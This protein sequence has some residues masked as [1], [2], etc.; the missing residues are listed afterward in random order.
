MNI[1]G[2]RQ[3]GGVQNK[4]KRKE[5]MN[6]FPSLYVGNLPKENFFDLDFFKFFTNKGY[7]VKSAKVVLDS[8]TQKSRGYG[9]LQFVSKG[10]ADKC[11][12]A[13]NNF[14]FHNQPLRIVDSISNPKDQF[15]EAANILVKNID[16]EVSQQEIHDLFKSHGTIVSCKLETFPDGGSRGY[17]FVQYKEEE[18]AK[19]A[20]S[21]LNGTEIRGKKL[22]VDP[23][24]KDQTGPAKNKSN[25]NLF[26]KNLPAGTDDIKLKAMFARFGEIESASLK[27]DEG[28][29]TKDY[30]WV[31][32]KDANNAQ[33][34]MTEMNKQL[35]ADGRVLIV[36]PFISKKENELAH[37]PRQIDPEPH[38]HLQF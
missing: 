9:Y 15:K 6:R 30:G 33:K 3:G 12:D 34:A 36:N 14:M 11:R 25:N 22:Q 23:Y 28:G 37:N 19:A 16:K 24:K 5:T 4:Q 7:N 17:A 2:N 29:Q 13:M 8:K 21:A 26:V 35:M 10:E 31:C 32:F 38:P 18:E 27:R 20:V 1:S